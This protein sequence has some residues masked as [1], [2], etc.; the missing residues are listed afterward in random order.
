MGG[1]VLICSLLSINTLTLTL[2]DFFYP[3]LMASGGVGDYFLIN[4]WHVAGVWQHV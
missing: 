1:A 4:V 3:A 2:Q